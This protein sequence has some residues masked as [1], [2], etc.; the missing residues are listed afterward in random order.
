MS[1][2]MREQINKIK[3]FGQFFNENVDRNIIAYHTSEYD[4]N[5]FNST[6]HIGN[7]GTVLDG[8]YFLSTINGL[9]NFGNFGFIYKVNI[10]PKNLFVFDLRTDEHWYLTTE[11][12]ELFSESLAGISNYLDEF[13]DEQ[14]INVNDIDCIS[15]TNVDYLNDKTTIEYIVLDDNII[16][17]I[18][19]QKLN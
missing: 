6:E 10:K 16:T 17:I 13:F 1:K 11:F 9:D 14:N 15:L 8:S 3:N 7:F 2:E 18:N 5:K 4:F 19:K 12:Q